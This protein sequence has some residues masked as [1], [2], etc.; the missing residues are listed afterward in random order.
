[1]KLKLGAQ[2]DTS[3]LSKEADEIMIDDS[4]ISSSCIE[5]TNVVSNCISA[6]ASGSQNTPN[7]ADDGSMMMDSDC[8]S[9]SSSS[10]R[11][12]VSLTS[13]EQPRHNNIS[14][15][16]FFPKLKDPRRIGGID[17]SGGESIS[18]ENGRLASVSSSSSERDYRSETESILNL[19][20]SLN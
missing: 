1:M 9:T 11:D 17:S 16:H 6:S 2:R 12:Q 3:A 8:S 14:I 18:T 15:I 7:S 20:R 5:G 4:A 10:S 13:S 19:R